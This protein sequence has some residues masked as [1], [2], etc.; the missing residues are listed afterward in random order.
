MGMMVMILNEIMIR[1]ARQKSGDRRGCSLLQISC[2][3]ETDLDEVF[4]F[5]RIRIFTGV[6]NY[7]DGLIFVIRRALFEQK[8]RR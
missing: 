6:P 4:F 7:S 3:V 1:R 5:S 2:S 8:Y